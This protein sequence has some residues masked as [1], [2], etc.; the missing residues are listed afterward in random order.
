MVINMQNNLSDKMLYDILGTDLE[1]SGLVDAR[2]REAYEIIRARSREIME[3]KEEHNKISYRTGKGKQRK[4]QPAKH[5]MWKK[6]VISFSSMAAVLCLTFIFCVM[7]PVMAREIPIL[8]NIFAK[9][10]DVF[11]FGNL[12]EEES[13]GLYKNTGSTGSSYQVMD[14]GLTVT[15]EQEYV[16]N[17]ALFIGVRIENEQAFPKLV[18]Y[19]ESGGQFLTMKTREN[20]SFRPEDPVSTRR[21]V[22][23]KFEDE[24]TF[25]GIMRIDFSE[26]S[27]DLRRYNQAV[28]EADEKGEEYPECDEEWIDYYEIPSEFD[29]SFEITQIVGTLETPVRPEGMKKEEELA[30]MTEEEMGRYWNS[31][32]REW[33]AFPNKYQH[34]YQDGKWTFEI[35]IVQKD[36]GTK[37]FDVHEEN[38]DGVGIESVK[39]SPVEM[40]VNIINK[41][42]QS[43]YP[44]VFDKNGEEIKAAPNTGGGY[45]Y[46]TEGHDISTFYIM[47]CSFEDW[48][49]MCTQFECPEN[50]RSF[51]ELIEECTVFQKTICMD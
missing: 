40:T 41:T 47:I 38:K 22:E 1:D 25:L 36:R 50:D 21:T 28:D 45:V 18:S 14:G 48:G 35:P 44:V 43:M 30:Q 20:Y 5:A 42:K 12:P 9:V 39:I 19:V 49:K 32:P 4:R 34:W 15:L 16:S 46:A 8:G 3:Q 11:P 23:G 7:N 13:V 6:M 24:H 33:V 10:A 51:L 31:L 2:M 27:S 29:M 37:I 17:Q 26:L